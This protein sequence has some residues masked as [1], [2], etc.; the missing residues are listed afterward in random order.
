ML[1]EKNIPP[2]AS[3]EKELPKFAF[4]PRFKSKF[5]LLSQLVLPDHSD[6]R[7]VFE[8]FARTRITEQKKDRK[9]KY[10]QSKEEI[11]KILESKS[12]TLDISFDNF[13][14]LLRREDP[15]R[16][17]TSKEK[18]KLYKELITPLKKEQKTSKSDLS[19][20]SIRIKR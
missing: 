18:E 4:D 5:K 8:E 16:L 9:E 3:Y 2:F 1:R 10:Q 11:E 17:L 7:D 6:R 14:D 19:N 12:F 20:L 15:F 13:K